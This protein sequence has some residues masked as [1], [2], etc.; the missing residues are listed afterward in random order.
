M[1]PID[2]VLAKVPISEI[3]I[4]TTINSC[5]VIERIDRCI[6]P[7]FRT[8]QNGQYFIFDGSYEGNYFF[9]RGHL[10]NCDGKDAFT[11]NSYVGFAFIRIPVKIET[12]PIFYGR[13]FNDGENGSTIKGHFGIPFP[14]LTLVIVLGLFAAAKLLPKWSEL[15]ISPSL[16]LIFLSVMH[17]D[18]FITERKGI[19]DLLKGLF[20]M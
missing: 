19:I 12:S 5:A 6:L 11:S 2:L 7:I 17:L 9:L 15:I 16:I 18:Q 3:T 20:L 14:T 10:K 1:N 4:K 13:V 8:R